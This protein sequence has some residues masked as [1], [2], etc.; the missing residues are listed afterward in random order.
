MK[1]KSY[2]KLKNNLYEIEFQNYE[3]IIL[4]DDVILK[5]ELLLKKEISKDLLGEMMLENNSLHC[6]Y[7]ALQYLNFKNRTKK[8]IENYLVQNNFQQ[9]EIERA[10]N[11]LENKKL[12]NEE[13]YL[14]A[15][16]NDQIHLTNNGPFKII[17]KLKDLGFQEKHIKEYLNTFSEEIWKE[18]L[19]SIIAKKMKGNKS[20]SIKKL[21]EKIVYNLLNEGFKKEDILEILENFNPKNNVDV[22]QKEASKLRIKLNKKYE[23]KELL[24]QIKKRL[25]NK[26]FESEEIL[27]ALE[28]LNIE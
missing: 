14:K 27:S 28:K 19:E 23:N 21:K 7:K 11:M 1:I 3:K 9:E 24:F 2:R 8:E 17:K 13:N 6:Y 5:Y 16:V 15:Y 25:L 22:V 18:K 26:G 20:L 12:I 4:Y 10:I